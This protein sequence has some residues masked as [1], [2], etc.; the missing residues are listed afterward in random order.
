M[1]SG[2]RELD[3]LF[4][5]LNMNILRPSLISSAKNPHFTSLKSL[6]ENGLKDYLFQAK[7]ELWF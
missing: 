1:E 2:G 5:L 7:K 4:N 3:L 6:Q